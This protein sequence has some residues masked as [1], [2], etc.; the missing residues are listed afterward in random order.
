MKFPDGDASARS[1]FERTSYIPGLN[2]RNI[3]RWK[4]V[5][6]VVICT[7]VGSAGRRNTSDGIAFRSGNV[8]LIVKARRGLRHLQAGGLPLFDQWRQV[9]D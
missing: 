7:G 6:N 1:G 8:S 4:V 9:L 5:V 2:R 3:I